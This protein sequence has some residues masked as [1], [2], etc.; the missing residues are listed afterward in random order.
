M[1][2]EGVPGSCALRCAT[3]RPSGGASARS[4]PFRPTS[5]GAPGPA[6]GGTPRGVPPYPPSTCHPQT[7]AEPVRAQVWVRTSPEGEG[8]RRTGCECRTWSHAI[9][10]RTAEPTSTPFFPHA[11]V[12]SGNPLP[13]RAP[14]RS[15]LCRQRIADLQSGSL[16]NPSPLRESEA[17]VPGW[18]E[19]GS[20]LI[21]RHFLSSLSPLGKKED[22]FLD[23]HGLG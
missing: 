19:G 9:S 15:L 2:V 18:G 17:R 12:G 20:L 4:P 5:G 6:Y 11:C 7:P 22:L 23:G 8:I 16:R 10:V 13:P 1:G 14:D 21:A 3:C